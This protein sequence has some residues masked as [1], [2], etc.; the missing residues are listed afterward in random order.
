MAIDFF[1]GYVKYRCCY[2]CDTFIMHE[3]IPVDQVLC[4]LCQGHSVRRVVF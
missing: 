2:C 3:N 4:P 1:E